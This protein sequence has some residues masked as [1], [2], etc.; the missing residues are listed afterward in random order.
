MKEKIAG[1]EKEIGEIKAK[2]EEMLAQ[3]EVLKQENEEKERQ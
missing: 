3:I 2:K 1:L